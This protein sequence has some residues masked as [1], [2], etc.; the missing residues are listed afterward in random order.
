ML[1]LIEIVYL[2]ISFDVYFF[3]FLHLLSFFIWVSLLN[4]RV[5]TPLRNFISAMYNFMFFISFLKVLLGFN[6]DT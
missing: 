3:V 6:L 4:L 5:R 2:F 1:K